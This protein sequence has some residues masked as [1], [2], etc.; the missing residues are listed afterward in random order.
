MPN[1]CDPCWKLCST[2]HPASVFH[3]LRLGLALLLFCQDMAQR[4]SGVNALS[5]SRSRVVV[6]RGSGA[7]CCL[8]LDATWRPP[9][10]LFKLAR[11]ALSPSALLQPTSFAPLTNTPPPTILSP[12]LTKKTSSTVPFVA[13]S[14]RCSLSNYPLRRD[15]S[16]RSC[17][18]YSL[19]L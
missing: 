8:S 2:L 11:P 5:L 19:S 7:F 4:S 9:T 1:L 15:A 3:R 17:R 10:N 12:C 6:L 16:R 18:H 13:A 14:G